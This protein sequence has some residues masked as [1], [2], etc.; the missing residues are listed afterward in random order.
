MCGVVGGVVVFYAL[1]SMSLCIVVVSTL[2]MWS[3]TYNGK[4]RVACGVWR[5]VYGV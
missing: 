5:V 1:V 4:M 2:Y 3:I